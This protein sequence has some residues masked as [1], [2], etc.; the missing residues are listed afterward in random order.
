MKIFISF[1]RSSFGLVHSK[2]SEAE[3]KWDI[4]RKVALL[5]AILL[6]GCLSSKFLPLYYE[7]TEELNLFSCV[8]IGLLASQP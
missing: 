6:R 4:P 1:F 5:S 3:L 2:L 8:Q 7:F